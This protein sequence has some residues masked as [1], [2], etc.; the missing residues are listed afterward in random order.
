MKKQER[1]KKRASEGS[2][3]PLSK[4]DDARRKYRRKRRF[5][6]GG[7]A[8]MLAALVVGVSHWLGHLGMFGAQPPLWSDFFIGYPTAGL[9]LVTGAIMAGQ[10]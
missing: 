9:L 6:R 7:Q 5:L 3:P 1:P 4:E 2:V 8:F 10:K